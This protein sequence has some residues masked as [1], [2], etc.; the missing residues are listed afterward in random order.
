MTTTPR[1]VGILEI[2]NRPIQSIQND[3]RAPE[4]DGRE[5][6][7]NTRQHAVASPRL[8]AAQTNTCSYEQLPSPATDTASDLGEILLHRAVHGKH[9]QGGMLIS[10][11]LF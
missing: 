6:E 7:G 3:S 2:E 4:S 5:I 10:C 9:Q 1:S 8:P 11:T